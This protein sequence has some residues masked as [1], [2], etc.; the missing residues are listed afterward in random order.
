MNQGQAFQVTALMAAVLLMVAP[1]AAA[2]T[3]TNF[4]DDTN[5]ASGAE[6]TYHVAVGSDEP[7]S[8]E[9][10]LHDGNELSLDELQDEDDVDPVGP[11]SDYSIVAARDDPNGNRIRLRRHFEI[12]IN[13][14]HNVATN[15][16]GEVVTRHCREHQGGN[17]YLYHRWYTLYECNIWGNCTAVEGPYRLRVVYDAARLP[18]DGLARG[19]VN[20]YC[21][22][23]DGGRICPAW[24]NGAT[25][26]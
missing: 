21:L 3:G 8:G 1:S 7:G 9:A 23:P 17:S 22:L 12:K 13:F 16:V 2:D 20:A 25:E 4:E 26:T 6:D 10:A 14:E 19:V 11:M 18:S 5:R 15:T 24:V